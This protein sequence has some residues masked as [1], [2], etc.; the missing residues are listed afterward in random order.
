[1]QNK[2]DKTKL[3]KHRNQRTETAGQESSS[4]SHQI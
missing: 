1:M 3:R 4:P 2:T